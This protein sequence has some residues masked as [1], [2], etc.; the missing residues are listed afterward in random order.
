MLQETF[1]AHKMTECRHQWEMTNI[2]VGLVVFERCHHCTGVRTYFT[3]ED[4]AILGDK[5]REGDHFWSRVENGQSFRFDLL[6]SKCGELEKF[7]DLMGLLYCTQCSP[8][9][10]LEMLRRKLEAQDTRLILVCGNLRENETKPRRIPSHKLNRL[11]NYFSQ[12]T[13]AT[14]VRIAVMPFSPEK[15]IPQCR[16]EFLPDMWMRSQDSPDSREPAFSS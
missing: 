6:C 14:G 16:F 8:D 3:S 1:G 11:K 13:D 12:R 15:G 4:F 9:C 5:Y 7:D 2:R 10:K